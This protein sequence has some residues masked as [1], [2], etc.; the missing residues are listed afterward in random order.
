MF[1]GDRGGYVFLAMEL[2]MHK[3]IRLR[4]KNKEK[5]KKTLYEYNVLGNHGD[6]K[7]STDTVKFLY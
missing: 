4:F 2:W 1:L 5:K 3:S 6:V 7:L